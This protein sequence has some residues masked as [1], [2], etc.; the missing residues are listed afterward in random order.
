MHVFAGKKAGKILQS[1]LIDNVY[2][3]NTVVISQ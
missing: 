2:I 3:K 1:T